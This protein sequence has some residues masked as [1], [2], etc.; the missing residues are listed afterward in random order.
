MLIPAVGQTDTGDYSYR[1]TA[2]PAVSGAVFGQRN[3]TALQYFRYYDPDTGRF[4]QSD[5]I[6]LLGDINLYQYAPNALLQI[7]PWGLNKLWI[8]NCNSNGRKKPFNLLSKK[9]LQ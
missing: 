1:D 3:R 5:L 6:G 4:T 9:K 8:K 7:D 2:E